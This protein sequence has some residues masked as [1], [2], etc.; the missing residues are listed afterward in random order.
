MYNVDLLKQRKAQLLEI[1]ADVRKTLHS[2]ID[3]GSFVEF[4][5]FGFSKN[6]FY[7]EETDGLGVLTGYA[8]IDGYPVYVVAQNSKVSGG[9]LSKASCDKINDCM[10]KA[11]SQNAPIIYLLES[12]GVKVGEGVAVL[13]GIANILRTSLEFKEVA[14]QFAIAVGD[15]YGSTSI[16]FDNSDF[17]FI[18]GNACVSYGS[19]QVISAS[20]DGNGKE[21]V[22]NIKNG[23]KTFKVNSIT[24]AK[25]KILSIIN[26]LPKFSGLEI[27]CLDDL[28]KSSPN[29]NNG[30]DA[31]SIIDATFDA[32]SFIKMN[33]G[34]ADEVIVG[35]GRIGGIST[36][37]I[38]MDGG[39]LGVELT[40]N[41]VLKIKNFATFINDNAMP[42]VLFVNCS[43]IKVDGGVVNSP[44]SVEIMNM[45]YNL[46]SIK[47]VTV[48]YGKA[49]GFG[50]SAFASKAFGSDYTY[51]FADSKI[52]LLDGFAGI[53][54]TF[55]T[56]DSQKIEELKD[57]YQASQ[58]VFNC[59][60]L[61]CVD[62]IIEP[63]FVRQYVLSALQMIIG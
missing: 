2:L 1:T 11:G 10:Q 29:L 26:T 7:G 16:L 45:L 55:G 47:R 59:A 38:V 30:A 53:S 18:V 27:D 28:N 6:E 23:S 40:L 14:P 32:N 54:A 58:D 41:N 33:E 36:A 49:I 20:I 13:E 51:A 52:S 56:V 37:G 12:Q 34:F 19:P 22:A 50:Y 9:A 17:N 48:V 5:T 43:G 39:E 25:D 57:K 24:D 42:L 15:V 62:N 4:N 35:I 46:C 63:E 21:T 8:T 60:K 61:G 3:E 44:V 31:Q